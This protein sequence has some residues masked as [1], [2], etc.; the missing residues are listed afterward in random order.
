MNARVI[1]GFLAGAAAGSLAGVLL[2]PEKGATTRK[3][4]AG[5]THDLAQSVKSN[6]NDFIDTLWH[7]FAGVKEQA[8]ELG[9]KATAKMNAAKKELK[10][11]LA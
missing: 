11:A 9:E 4:I 2:A 8:E 10:S 7:S 3:K 6:F 1:L 5:K